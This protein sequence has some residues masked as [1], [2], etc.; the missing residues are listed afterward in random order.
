MEPD[1]VVFEFCVM[2]GTVQEPIRE[3]FEVDLSKTQ[4]SKV[5]REAIRKALQE[6]FPSAFGITVRQ[7]KQIPTK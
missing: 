6:A 7:K 5:V 4:S 2:N 3:I 1:P